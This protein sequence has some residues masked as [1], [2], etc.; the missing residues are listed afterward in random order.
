MKPKVFSYTTT[1]FS[2]D[3]GGVY[4]GFPFDGMNIFGKRGSIRINCTIDG[5]PKKCSLLPMGDG[6]HAIHVRKDIRE[7]IGKQVGDEVD[8]WIEQDLSVRVV[9]I[10]DDVQW[11]LDDDPDLKNKFEKL[12][13]SYKEQIIAYINQAR[14]AETRARRIH[15]FLDRIK[16]GLRRE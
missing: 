14:Q 9:I 11:L 15:M 6:T 1:L 13:V 7:T 8:I 12:S 4:A 5:F 10:P 16:N 3:R 2:P